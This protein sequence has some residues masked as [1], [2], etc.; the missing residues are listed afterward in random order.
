MN[1]F[2]I[3]KEKT[4][5]I[6]NPQYQSERVVRY[7]LHNKNNSSTHQIVQ[8]APVNGRISVQRAINQVEITATNYVH[9]VQKT[10]AINRPSWMATQGKDSPVSNNFTFK[11]NLAPNSS[12]A[13]SRQSVQRNVGRNSEYGN[14]SMMSPFVNK[15]RT[16]RSLLN[17]PDFNRTYDG[18]R[19]QLRYSLH[20]G[21]RPDQAFIKS[22]RLSSMARQ[23]DRSMDQNTS[24]FYELE[25]RI[26]RYVMYG[27]QAVNYKNT[28]KQ[29]DI[30]NEY[31]INDQ[32]QV[33]ARLGRESLSR[34]PQSQ[35]KNTAINEVKAQNNFIR[36][37]LK[38]FEGQLAQDEQAEQPKVQPE[39]N[40]MLQK[41]SPEKNAEPNLALKCS[42]L[43][44]RF[45]SGGII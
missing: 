28:S 39:I 40:P 2:K 3:L 6:A 10:S 15:D 18:Y 25:N 8:D 45:S 30:F 42:R 36:R 21:M 38:I 37:R 44:S 9:P 34:A 26:S 31:S 41:Q 13:Y 24:N 23:R 32:Q 1:E 17:A 33:S 29:L 16:D 27:E 5:A 35:P 43:K 7:S 19:H 12:V 14:V 11:E 20:H 22:H 4:N